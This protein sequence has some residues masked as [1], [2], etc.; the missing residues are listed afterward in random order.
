MERIR[1]DTCSVSRETSC[2]RRASVP[3]GARRQ[4]KD[5]ARRGGVAED[6]IPPGDVAAEGSLRPSAP[7]RLE[8]RGAWRRK[9]H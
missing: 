8:A 3:L 7:A 4:R 1:P 2:S 5:K 6:K 9:G